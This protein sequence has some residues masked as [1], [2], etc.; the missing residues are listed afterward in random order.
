[1]VAGFLDEYAL[2]SYGYKGLIYYLGIV[3]DYD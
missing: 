3:V 2:E 1:M